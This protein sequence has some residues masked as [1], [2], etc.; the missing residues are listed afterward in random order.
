MKKLLAYLQL[1]RLPNVFTAMADI[2][3][4]FLFVRGELSPPTSFV[5]LLIASSLLYIAGMVL[6][7]VFDVE[8]DTKERPERPI[9]SGRISRST[10]QSLGFGMLLV[11]LLIAW[12][13]GFLP[14]GGE[15]A[16]IGWRSGVIGTLLAGCIV[17]YDA[18]MKRTPAGPIFMGACRT[19]NILLGM[20]V[21]V[22]NSC[23]GSVWL[24]RFEVEQLLVAGSVGIYIAGVTWFAR[25]EAAESNR[26]QLTGG[27]VTMVAG[28]LLLASYPLLF[29]NGFIEKPLFHFRGLNPIMWQLLIVLLGFTIARSALMAVINPHPQ[30]VQ[31]A[32]KTAITSLIVLDAAICMIVGPYFAIGV[33]VLL[34]PML[35]LGRWVY[36]T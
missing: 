4:G 15:S 28:L 11:G 13:V 14:A 8:Q 34:A 7:D 16:A 3:A 5:L 35:L 25:T 33:L 6:N 12:V 30:R 10:A 2:V 20:S 18:V 21:A 32:V 9:P 17:A 22:Q 19:L 31:N 23:G 36:S 29:Q 1:F 27:L 26:G 24:M